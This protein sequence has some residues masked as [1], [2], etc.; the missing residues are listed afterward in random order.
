MFNKAKVVIK[1]DACMKFYDETKP[2]YIEMDTCGAGLGAALLQTRNNTSC[3]KDE[4]QDNNI[5]RPSAFFSKNLTGAGKRYSNIEREALGILYELEKCYH[6]CIA[7]EVSIITD[8]K[9][10]VAIFKKRCCNII[11]EIAVN[12]YKNTSIQ[13]ENY[14]QA[15]T[16]SIHSR[17]AIQ[18]KPQ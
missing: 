10:L 14:I 13:S 7:R 2:L 12:S 16:R 9:L 8:H 3:T 1:E 15:W 18:T 17:L 11:T 6:Y 4:A 5:L